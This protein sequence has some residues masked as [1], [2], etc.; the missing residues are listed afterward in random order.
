MT[1]TF[2][3]ARASARGANTLDRLARGVLAGAAGGLIGAGA[4]LLGEAIF[5]PRAPGEPVPPAVMVSRMVRYLSGSPL[6]KDRELLA[7]QVFHWSF[8]VA[9]GM[10]YG[11]LVEVSPR[12]RAGR[13]VAFGLALCLATHETTLP[14]LGLSL[15][16]KDI[17][18]KEHLSE[19]LSHA[20]F[21]FCTEE[22]RGLVRSR[23]LS[24]AR[25][26]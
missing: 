4:K 5:P 14:L 9:A 21:G 10:A 13:G 16:W 25:A 19:L 23:V 1:K 8:S 7:T 18:L 11:A 6:R 15:P 20:L 3:R 24:G 17:P 26:A 2:A 12:A 22:V